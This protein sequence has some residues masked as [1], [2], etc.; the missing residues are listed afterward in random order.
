M[1]RFTIAALML[2]L[3]TLS[4]RAADGVVDLAGLKSKA[5]AAW[6]D[7]KPENNMQKYR[8]KIDKAAGDPED[9]EMIVY[10][11]GKGQGGS[12]EENLKR[13]KGQ[14]KDPAAEKSKTD[15]FKVGDAQITY[16]D[17]AG[18]LVLRVPQFDPNGKIVE[19]PDFRGLHV[20]FAT[21]SGNYF[22]RFRGPAKT[23]AAQKPAFDE[24]L[25]NFK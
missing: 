23:I 19:K 16:L 15:K 14:F 17:I 6:K 10:F 25:K 20:V 5:P 24:W 21:N 1:R 22:I 3:T 9:S 12:V 4:A 8:F 7:Q 11:F 2:A 13:W 18:T